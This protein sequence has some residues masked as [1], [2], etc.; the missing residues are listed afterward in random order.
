MRSF[1]YKTASGMDIIYVVPFPGE[2][3]ETVKVHNGPSRRR[4][5]TNKHIYSALRPKWRFFS[6]NAD[7]LRQVVG[8]IIRWDLSG[9][10]Y[11]HRQ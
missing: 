6:R 2:Y 1:V 11:W 9:D 3:A 5:G 4:T 10:V 7:I 8:C